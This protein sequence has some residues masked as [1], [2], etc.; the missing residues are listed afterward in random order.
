MQNHAQMIHVYWS[1]QMKNHLCHRNDSKVYFYPRKER[2]ILAM[3][4]VVSWSFK[5]SQRLWKAEKQISCGSFQ[6]CIWRLKNRLKIESFF[7]SVLLWCKVAKKGECSVPLWSFNFLSNTPIP[8][9]PRIARI[10]RIATN[11][12]FF[13]IGGDSW[14]FIIFFPQSWWATSHSRFRYD[15]VTNIRGNR[16][17][18]AGI[19]QEFTT[20][21]K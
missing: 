9:R 12:F 16:L 21:R 6:F 2:K 3:Q 10:A 19:A 8:H 13:L 1:A 11:W 5:Q 4:N 17:Y 20:I 15:V 14:G 18:S 7:H